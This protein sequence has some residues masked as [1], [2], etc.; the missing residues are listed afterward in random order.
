MTWVIIGLGNPDEQY[1]RTRHNAGRMAVQ[2]FALLYDFGEWK[3]D[4]KSK[5]FIGRG[6]V[7]R[8]VTVAVLPNTYMNKTGSAAAHY[9]KPARPGSVKGAEKLIAVYDDLD[10]PLGTIKVSFDRGSGG[11]RGI[12]SI[13]TALKTKKFVRIRIGISPV[14]AKGVAKKPEGEKDVEKFIL[15]EFKA[16]EMAQLKSV[17]KRVSEALKTIIMEGREIAMNRFN[18]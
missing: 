16:D 3:E 7:E 18:Q 9:I 2:K 5:S 12:D 4:S 15:G 17:F 14:S 10:L 1:A 8:S 13:M 6:L 11:H